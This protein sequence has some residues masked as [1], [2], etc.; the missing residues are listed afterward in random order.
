MFNRKYLCDAK[1]DLDTHICTRLNAGPTFH[2]EKPNC[3]TY[4]RSI[5]YSGCID[6]NGLDSSLRNLDNIFE[7]KR[8]Q[9]SWLLNTYK[10]IR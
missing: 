1:D 7:F 4:K 5:C 10:N 2:I 8:L 9:K 6:W 3:E